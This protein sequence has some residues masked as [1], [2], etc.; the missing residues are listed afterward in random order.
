MPTISDG[1]KEILRDYLQAAREVMVWKLDGLSEYDVRRPMTPTGTNLL[2]LVKHL[3]TCEIGYFSARFGRPFPDPPSWLTAPHAPDN[4]D[5]W[6]TPDESRADI[7]DTYRRACTHSDETFAANELD[8]VV[9][10]WNK[11]VTLQWL[12]AHM[13]AETHRHAG[14]ADIVRETIDGAVGMR[15]YRGSI[16]D[17]DWSAHHARVQAAAQ[18][19]RA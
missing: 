10:A 12:L 14:H 18:T 2:G 1:P 4:V 3:T 7:V 5:M 13:I 19:F 17:A 16:P 9:R 11:D 6:A 8:T 15:S